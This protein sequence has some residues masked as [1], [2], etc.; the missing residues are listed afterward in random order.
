M[1]LFATGAWLSAEGSRSIIWDDLLPKESK[2]FDD[3]F[4]EL[5]EEQLLDLGMV[6]R[7]R[8]LLGSEK[9]SADGSDAAEAKKL[10]AKLEG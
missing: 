4:D 3:P 10:V 7:I 5:T 6:A 2:T 9:I 1:F 8:F